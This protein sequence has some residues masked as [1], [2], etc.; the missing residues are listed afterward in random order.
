MSLRDHVYICASPACNSVPRPDGHFGKVPASVSPMHC[1]V[2]K[3]SPES[4]VTSSLK[5]NLVPS[6]DTA[7]E[8]V[9]VG[10]DVT[11]FRVGDRVCANFALDH[12]AGD[13][14][15]EIGATAQGGAIDGGL[16]EYRVYPQHVS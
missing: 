5:E 15:P 8:I 10:S 13:P 3:S 4:E 9:A 14:T 12:I 11:R 2:S 7:A 16:T 6:S 1:N